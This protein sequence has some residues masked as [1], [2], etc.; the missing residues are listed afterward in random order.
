MLAFIR[1]S[2]ARTPLYL[3]RFVAFVLILWAVV[4]KNRSRD[5]CARGNPND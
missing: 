1:Q 3:I 4:D 2:E 5:A